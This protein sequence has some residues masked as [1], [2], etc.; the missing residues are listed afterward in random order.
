[1][2][3]PGRAF[4]VPTGQPALATCERP[5]PAPGVARCGRLSGLHPRDRLVSHLCHHQLLPD[6]HRPTLRKPGGYARH[7]SPGPPSVQRHIGEPD[8]FD[9]G[10]AR[11]PLWLRL[12]AFPG[13]RELQLWHP[14]FALQRAGNGR[15]HR[16]AAGLR[17]EPGRRVVSLFRQAVRQPL[18]RFPAGQDPAGTTP[19]EPGDCGTTS[20]L[21]W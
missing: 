15:L 19:V 12:P 1:M 4:V 21:S 13:E 9:P 14:R 2:N 18:L 17:S 3:C 7:G 5:G 8:E 11:I 10:R 6:L 20:T 16:F